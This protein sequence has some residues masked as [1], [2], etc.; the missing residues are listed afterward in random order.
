MDTRAEHFMD[1]PGSQCERPFGEK[2]EGRIYHWKFD[3]ALVHAEHDHTDPDCASSERPNA[4]E[5]SILRELSAEYANL[6]WADGRVADRVKASL[7][8]LYQERMSN[9]AKPAF[10]SLSSVVLGYLDEGLFEQARRGALKS[11]SAPTKAE[12]ILLDQLADFYGDCGRIDN[13][14]IAERAQALVKKLRALRPR[15]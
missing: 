8:E 2:L 3:T 6:G 4:R 10:S 15:S 14:A 1:T 9:H 13:E 12:A 7:A 5:M 11:K